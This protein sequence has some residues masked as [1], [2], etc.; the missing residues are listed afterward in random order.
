MLE[1]DGKKYITSK[2]WHEQ[3]ADEKVDAILSY[4]SEHPATVFLEL[5]SLQESNYFMQRF[6]R[7]RRKRP[8]YIYLLKHSVK[9]VAKFGVSR[10]FHCRFSS[11]K[12]FE[13]VGV[14]ETDNAFGIENFCKDLVKETGNLIRGKE[15]FKSSYLEEIKQTIEESISNNGVLM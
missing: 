15:Y 9:P 2:E 8:D 7:S 10:N 3:G 4:I 14:W 12:G 13:I 11:Y 5:L 1:Y 6:I